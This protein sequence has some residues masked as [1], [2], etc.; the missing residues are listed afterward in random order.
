MTDTLTEYLVI[1]VEDGHDGLAYLCE[2]ES[3]AAAV[4]MARDEGRLSTEEFRQGDTTVTKGM[5]RLCV[6]E[7]KSLIG[8]IV[9]DD[10]MRQMIADDREL[11]QQLTSAYR[12]ASDE[13]SD[14][15]DTFERDLVCEAFAIFLG[16]NEGWPLNMATEDESE[17]FLDLVRV[18][19]KEGKL[20]D[21]S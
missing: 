4:Q 10:T 13:G 2:A 20:E 15:L 12:D 17:F 16:S 21:A 14:S 18:A 9:P 19:I 1:E 8:V 5:V 3:W 7:I 11:R 6:E